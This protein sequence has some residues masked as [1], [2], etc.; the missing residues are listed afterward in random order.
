MSQRSAW[1]FLSILY[2]WSISGVAAMT[3]MGDGLPCRREFKINWQTF[4]GITQLKFPQDFDVWGVAPCSLTFSWLLIASL[5]SAFA[6]NHLLFLL[7]LR[8]LLP[9]CR[10]NRKLS[11]MLLHTMCDVVFVYRL[12]EPLWGWPQPKH[13]SHK[14]KTPSVNEHSI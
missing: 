4:L 13:G 11:T 12:N 8:L 3:T 7:L 2:A 10:F 9:Q 1:P 14:G 5:L 6:K